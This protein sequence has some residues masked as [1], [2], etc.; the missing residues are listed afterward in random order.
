MIKKSTRYSCQI[1]RKLEYC[2]QFFKKI[3]EYQISSKSIHLELS[4][5]RTDI[6]KLIVPFRNFANGPKKSECDINAVHWCT[7]HT[8][9]TMQE[10]V[11][12]VTMCK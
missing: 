7:S 9:Y 4:S 11:L 2:Q 12:L 6:T 8:S 10:R 3:L 1:L 5:M